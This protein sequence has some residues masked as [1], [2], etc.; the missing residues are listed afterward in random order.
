MV[1]RGT[2]G[3]RRKESKHLKKKKKNSQRAWGRVYLCLGIKGSLMRGIMR[4][5]HP[6]A[7]SRLEMRDLISSLNH[8]GFPE[9]EKEKRGGGRGLRGGLK[10]SREWVEGSQNVFTLLCLSSHVSSC[11]S[12]CPK[13]S[14]AE[15]V[16]FWQLDSFCLLLAATSIRALSVSMRTTVEWRSP[17][18]HVRH[19]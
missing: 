16:L 13:R 2:Q 12:V 6:S 14:Q 19:M 4:P 15:R 7:T 11:F 17:G 18:R 5:G 10:Q 9:W 1:H 3:P 8:L